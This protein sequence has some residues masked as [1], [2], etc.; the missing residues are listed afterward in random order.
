MLIGIST[1][2]DS[3]GSKVPNA[4]DSGALKPGYPLLYYVFFHPTMCST[5][6]TPTASKRF[7]ARTDHDLNH[8]PRTHHDL[9]FLRQIL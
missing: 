6:L 9:D 3:W 4:L 2:R 7:I 1:G 5:A 8:L